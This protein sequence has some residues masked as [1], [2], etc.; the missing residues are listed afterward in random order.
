MDTVRDWWIETAWW[1]SGIFATGAVWY[2]L[3]TRE[4]PL[5]IAAGVV[6]VVLAAVAIILHRKKDALD[7]AKPRQP[8]QRDKLVT[9]PWWEASD[10]RKDY[11]G[12]GLNHFHWSNA[13]RVPEREQQSHEI[14][15]LDDMDANIRYRIVNKSGQVLMAKRDA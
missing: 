5:A 2:F 10:L 8:T 3:S 4:Y 14:V 6:A 7:D 12:R 13:D 9:S 15:Y 11:E 1:A